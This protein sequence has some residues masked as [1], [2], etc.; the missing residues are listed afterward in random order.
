M[1][2]STKKASTKPKPRKKRAVTSCSICKKKGHNKKGCPTTKEKEAAAYKIVVDTAAAEGKVLHHCKFPL[3]KSLV[4]ETGY[5]EYCTQTC[6]WFDRKREASRRKAI[7]KYRPEYA[8]EMF[9]EY[10]K[11]VEL[12]HSPRYAKVEDTLVP[13]KRVQIPAVG[14]YATYL[15][16]PKVTL[17]SWAMR[18]PEF[19]AAMLMLKQVQEY[20]LTNYGGV[21]MY[22]PTVVKMMLMNNHGM[23]DRSERTVNHLFGIV[24]EVYEKADA[25]EQD[26]A[27]D[28]P[29]EGILGAGDDDNEELVWV[30]TRTLGPTPAIH[31]M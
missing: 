14:G 15:G 13:I 25:Y 1:T 18:H 8:N 3:C 2:T 29:F 10:L 5:G 4:D 27:L 20:Y 26:G 12:S 24:R 7:E 19:R 22:T 17:K 21:G 30:T 31:N 9:Y 28:D 16:Y 23:K 6:A 11:E